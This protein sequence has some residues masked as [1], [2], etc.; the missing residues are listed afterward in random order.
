M[1][2]NLNARAF[3]ALSVALVL[4]AC[5]S[6][7]EVERNG[8]TYFVGEG[9]GGPLNF[10]VVAVTRAGMSERAARRNRSAFRDVATPRLA[11]VCARRNRRPTTTGL[12]NAE[13]AEFSMED[14]FPTWTFTRNCV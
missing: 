10:A 2:M 1:L 13:R 9:S 12:A 11:S 14:G 8:V 6:V 4:S 3:I 7:N 5:V